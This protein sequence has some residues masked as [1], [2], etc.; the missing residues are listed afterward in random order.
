MQNH[1]RVWQ[2]PD[3][4]WPLHLERV[5]SEE[6]A[7]GGIL[8]GK[9]GGSAWLEVKNGDAFSNNVK[10]RQHAENGQML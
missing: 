7:L 3:D 10:V 9:A 2:G 4:T 5:A 1:E 6:D 8:M